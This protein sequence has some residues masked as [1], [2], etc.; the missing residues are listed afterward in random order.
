[1]TANIYAKIPAEAID[2][3]EAH[4]NKSEFRVWLYLW[5]VDAFGDKMRVFP[6]P[7][8]I[9]EALNLHKRTVTRACDTLEELGIFTYKI[10][11]WQGIN[12][13]GSKSDQARDKLAKKFQIE[14]SVVSGCCDSAVQNLT[15]RSNFGQNDPNRDSA[16]QNLTERSQKCT[17]LSNFGQ[18]CQN[19]G[20][21][22]APEASF[23]PSNNSLI[24]INNSLTNQGE[25]NF[26]E[27]RNER[28]EE[29]ID[30][31]GNGE[32]KNFNQEVEIVESVQATLKIVQES[33]NQKGSNK[34]DSEREVKPESANNGEDH[35]SAAP[36]ETF[37]KNLRDF[38]IYEAKQD[39]K[40]NAPE[41]WADTVIRR[42]RADWQEKWAAWE[43]SRAQTTTYTPPKVEISPDPDVR[44][45]AVEEAKKLLPEWM[46][47][48]RG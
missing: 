4:L 25:Q 21:K 30:F 14:T 3:A 24:T 32:E 41:I 42:N 16:V 31:S 2:I 17:E 10:Q 38:V 7:E 34:A 39:P 19:Q 33:L 15:E 35:F 12:H 26:N 44:R 18:D 20:S 8:K 36:P 46:R 9:G 6:S 48:N 28:E 29:F 11:E 43:K 40:I 13:Y 45:R 47:R 5:K 1:M 23:T 22:V 37:F 27:T